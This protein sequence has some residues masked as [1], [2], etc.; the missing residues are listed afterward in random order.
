MI[1]KQDYMEVNLLAFKEEMHVEN[2]VND[3][4]QEYKVNKEQSIVR[5][6]KV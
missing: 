4:Q 3:H 1:V 6:G 5:R 2:M